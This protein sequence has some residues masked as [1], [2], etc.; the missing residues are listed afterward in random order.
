M[1]QGL[2]LTQQLN[3]KLMLKP[4]LQQSL[5]ILQLSN[6]DLIQYLNE[7][8]MENPVL[9]IE[10][11]PI[12]L[13]AMG[14]SSQYIKRGADTLWGVQA[15]KET[16]EHILL[17]QLRMA[18]NPAHLY[19]IA[20]FLAGNL[21]DAGYLRISAAD[22]AACLAQPEEAVEQALAILQSLEPAGVGARD[23][24]ECLLLQIAR[25]PLAVSGADKVVGEYLQLLAQ[26]KLDKIALQTKLPLSEVNRIAAYIRGLQPRPWSASGSEEVVY[27]VPDAFIYQEDGKTVIRMNQGAL[28][29][30]TLNRQWDSVPF[31][32]EKLKSAMSIVHGLKQR[33]VTLYRVILAI[34]DEQASFLSQGEKALKPLTLRV[35]S[36]RLQVHESTVSRAVQGK[37]VR[38][39]FGVFELKQF[40]CSALATDS[41]EHASAKRVKIRLKE[42]I[43]R[44]NKQSPLSDQKLVDIL[45]REGVRISR[46]TVTK[47]REELN[48]LSSS[49]RKRMEG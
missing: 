2:Q 29:Q 19:K 15:R 49:L 35:V 45:N 12:S 34:F 33:Q 32:K 41:G 16:L 13:T 47:Y 17:S 9:E 28:P 21:D 3:M 36:E 6:Y 7:E 8:A 14:K 27:T 30:L 42:L 20:A 26:A 31:M 44:E 4:E 22:T 37:F 5:H 10:A 18:N 23:L 38:T 1:R 43:A 24:R 11:P 25:D 48:V 46:R 39:Q 40:F